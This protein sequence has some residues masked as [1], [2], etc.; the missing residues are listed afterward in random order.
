MDHPNTYV[1]N[2]RNLPFS[3]DELQDYKFDENL[4]TNRRSG[5]LSRRAVQGYLSASHQTWVDQNFVVPSL[6]N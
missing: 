1:H 4:T 5:E 6:I 3:Q 2:L